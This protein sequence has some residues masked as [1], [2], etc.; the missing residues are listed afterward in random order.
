MAL[1][2]KKHCKYLGEMGINALYDAF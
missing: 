2:L 1:A